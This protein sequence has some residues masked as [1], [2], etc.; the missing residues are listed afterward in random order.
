MSGRFQAAWAVA[1]HLALSLDPRQ[2]WRQV[3]MVGSALVATLAVLLGASITTSGAAS[4]GHLEARDPVLA[5]EGRPVALFLDWSGPVV[6]GAFGQVSMIWLEPVPELA[7]DPGLV[8]P[9]LTH[10]PEPGEA[11]LSPGLLRAGLR[12]EDFGL[13]ESDSGGGAAGAIGAEGLASLS[14]GL[15][16][17]RPLPG[18]SIINEGATAS[19]GYDVA[20]ERTR[21]IFTPL[22]VPTLKTGWLGSLWL[23]WLPSLLLVAGAA[24][25]VPEALEQ[26]AR[27]L[28]SL[29]VAPSSIRLIAALEVAV[30]TLVG[31]L[32]G[33]VL[34]LVLV[35]GR[36]TFPLTD[37][38]LLDGAT[39]LV[40]AYVVLGL[41]VVVATAVIA[42]TAL[43]VGL[44][45]RRQKVAGVSAWR[46]V[47]LIVSVLTMYIAP[48]LFRI[49]PWRL[50]ADVMTLT[51]F[52]GALGTLVSLPL[53][54]PVLARWL[55]VV[56]SAV[57]R[58]TLW[59][60]GRRIG[61][62]AR[63]LSRPGALVGCLVFISGVALAVMNGIQDGGQQWHPAG[64]STSVFE[65]TWRNA[66]PGDVADLVAA[67]DSQGVSVA[68]MTS[69]SPVDETVV[70]FSR[71]HEEGVNF[72]TCAAAGA[73]F[74]VAAED[75]ACGEAEGFV[76]RELGYG[77][78]VGQATGSDLVVDRVLISTPRNWSDLDVLQ[79]TAG[80]PGA[81]SSLV[82]GPDDRAPH[83][84][85]DWLAAGWVAASVLLLVALLRTLGD[86]V[87]RQAGDTGDLLRA[88]LDQAEVSRT[89][90]ATT[91]LPVLLALPLG[92]AAAVIFSLRGIR[93]GITAYNLS[94]IVVV[95]A[96]VGAL[97][98]AVMVGSLA[99]QRRMVRSS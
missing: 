40:P 93:V 85:I 92:F 49:L 52:A 15:V 96:A 2:R 28:W 76:Q 90:T 78:Q 23:L 70:E 59:L 51:L 14:E 5:P 24:R 25:A 45:K 18:R 50:N 84:G 54:L 67:A 32:G 86:R 27:V 64:R 81:N 83:P 30:L 3:S 36:Q 57:R 79:V 99:W 34:W 22:D 61:G 46:V 66:E 62:S 42:S 94:L 65:V 39:N 72:T 82:L 53:A 95:T 21:V 68:P 20:G 98:L 74:G 63:V 19:V 10:L 75:L 29:G 6:P 89:L 44:I 91:L 17:A 43:P 48:D 9:G 4:E 31:G 26:R 37:G 1:R 16:Y 73:F 35:S 33:I 55:S 11:V 41:A 12:A 8:P 56:L 97:A 60:A 7:D 87:M 71:P 38:V 69:V 13:T 77:L 80:L 58:P 47:P 88:G